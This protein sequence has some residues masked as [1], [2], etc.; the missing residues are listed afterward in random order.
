MADPR[1]E[2]AARYVDTLSSSLAA[3]SRAEDRSLYGGHLARAAELFAL[4]VHGADEQRIS[5]WME[6]ERHAFGW[7]Y[8]SG[9]A[10]EA[11]ENAFA[12]LAKAIG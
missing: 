10:G 6:T 12:D 4:L 11:A 8:L 1:L 7:A 2:A 3:T 9:A 5:D